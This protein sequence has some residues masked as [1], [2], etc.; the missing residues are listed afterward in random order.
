MTVVIYEP[1]PEHQHI[2]MVYFCCVESG[3]P[4]QSH[5]AENPIHWFDVPELQS[6]SAPLAGE[7]VRFPPDVRALGLEAIRLV[8]IAESAV[9]S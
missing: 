2:D 1:E 5:D 4:G 9:L 3:Y 7:A 8:N 6:G